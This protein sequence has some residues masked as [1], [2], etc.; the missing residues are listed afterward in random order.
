HSTHLG[1]VAFPRKRYLSD[2][3]TPGLP[4]LVGCQRGADQFHQCCCLATSSLRPSCHPGCVGVFGERAV[5]RFLTVTRWAERHRIPP[6]VPAAF[7]AGLDP[8]RL[9]ARPGLE[10][11]DAAAVRARAVAACTF[12]DAVAI[13]A[14]NS[15]SSP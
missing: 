4:K 12:Q 13:H 3:T 1:G 5:P 14:S 10:G 8:M 7:T 9:T 15:S 2:G 6:R 11:R